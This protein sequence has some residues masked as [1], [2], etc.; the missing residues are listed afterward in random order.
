MNFF[1]PITELPKPWAPA[2]AGIASRLQSAYRT[3]R[4]TI[5]A[6]AFVALFT[7]LGAA[8]F[9]RHSRFDSI[10]AFITAAKDFQPATAKGDLSSLFTIPEMGEENHGK[11]VTAT[12][13]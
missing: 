9:V 3:V 4:T 1:I 10:E 6:F 8:D 12:N 11:L 7:P 5:L 13:I 2:K